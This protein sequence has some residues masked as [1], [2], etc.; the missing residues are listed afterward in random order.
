MD[1]KQTPPVQ[2]TTPKRR[3]KSKLQRFK[4][5]YLP[6]LIAGV[7]LILII[8]FI[9]GS[10]GLKKDRAQAEADAKTASE[11]LQAEADALEAEAALLAAGYDYR[12][13]MEV[14]GSY[15]GGLNSAPALKEKFDAYAAAAEGSQVW[16]D[17]SKIPNLS[18]RSLIPDLPRALADERYGDRF[19]R[20]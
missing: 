13:A 14:L 18:F 10:I 5:K 8:I 16:D 15:T 17:L 4:E 2:A 9:A 20:N 1:E 12:G 3:P 6:F 19:G 7:A 11:L